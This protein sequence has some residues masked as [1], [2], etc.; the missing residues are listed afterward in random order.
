ME[1]I[2]ILMCVYE[3]DYTSDFHDAL[4]SLI[5]NSNYYTELIL[6]R[7]GFISNNKIKIIDKFK[8]VLKIEIIELD[9]NIGLSKALNIGIK[10]AKYD[11]I[12]R[13]DSDDLC[14]KDRF[15]RIQEIIYSYGDKYDVFGTYIKEFIK[16]EKNILSE[17]KV[18]LNHISISNKLILSNPMNH[19]TVFFKKSLVERFSNPNFYPNIDGFEDY[20]LWSKLLSSGVKF[21]NFPI[22]TVYVRIGNEMLKRRGGIKYL[23]KEIKLR[24]YLIKF[25]NKKMIPLN[26]IICL[27]RL[28]AFSFPFFI[29]KNI[30]KLIR[31]NI[32]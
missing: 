28:I 6:V 12:A 24:F 2:S 23:Y 1:N 18:P 32:F 31:K 20:A 30:Y 3:G 26:L 17:R 7:N 22:T 9:K 8:R 15:E 16:N 19:V 4:E 5:P 13:F 14:S 29:K 10:E 11:W 25:I 21:I 27:I